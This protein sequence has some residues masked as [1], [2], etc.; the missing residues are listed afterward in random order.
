VNTITYVINGQSLV[1]WLHVTPQLATMMV[2]K[3]D[4]QR[5]PDVPFADGGA[6][7]YPVFSLTCNGEC[8]RHT[9]LPIGW[10]FRL[11]KDRKVKEVR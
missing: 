10:G 4:D 8:F 5:L 6:E 9:G 2:R 7:A 1:F 11:T 3:S